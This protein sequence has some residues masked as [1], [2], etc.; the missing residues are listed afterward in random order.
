M[1]RPKRQPDFDRLRK[2]LLCREPDRVPVAE[3][4]VDQKVKDAFMGKPVRDIK[5]DVEFWAA[6]GYD[7]IRLR[8]KYDFQYL[9][10]R[11]KQGAY[12]VYGNGAETRKWAE[13]HKGIIT[14]D[15][16]FDRF[17]WPT[18]SDIDFSNVEEAARSLLDGMK[19]I[20]S[21][22]GIFESV[23]MLMGF[24]SFSFALVENPDLVERMF[25]TL[26]RLHYD[27]F[28]TAADID[29]V[30]AMWYTDDLAYTEGLLVSPDVLRRH[31]FPWMRKMKQVCVEKDIPML[32][33]S[34][35]DLREIMDDLLDTG[36]NALHPIEPKA[37]DI[38]ELKRT[39]GDRVC[40]I[41]NIDLGY[42]LTRGSPE[43]VRAEVRRRIADLAPGGGYC[44]GSSNTV[45][46]YVP[47]ENFKAMI[48]AAFEFGTYPIESQRATEGNP[49]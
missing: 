49:E 36:I 32:F 41:G 21:S 15:E 47:L 22:T 46:N 39:V 18:I 11:E 43:E 13:Q 4:K 5:S 19:V 7:Y 17:D 37:M 27:I 31:V 6:A 35:G 44:V 20:S 10:S 26:G 25:D 30:G 33:H 16:E 29:N 8:A 24:E 23:W 1:S 14:N 34:D 9:A 12:N 2:A 42:T 40:L 28:R 3:L 38:N 48:E 45:T